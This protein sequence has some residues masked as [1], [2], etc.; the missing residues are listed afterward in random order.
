MLGRFLQP[1]AAALVNEVE[2]EPAA[3]ASALEDEASAI[4]VDRHAPLLQAE[5]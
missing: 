5:A 2:V 3:R 1:N 4:L